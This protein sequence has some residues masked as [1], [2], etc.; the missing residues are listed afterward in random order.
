MKAR[1]PLSA[2]ALA[3][4]A[5]QASATGFNDEA[6]WQAAVGSFQEEQ[7]EGFADLT[8][9]CRL[10][11]VDIYMNRLVTLTHAPTVMSSGTT[12]GS[13]TSGVNVLVN[14]MTPVLPGL[15][16]IRMF[17]TKAG[18]SI[19]GL[20]YWNT[21]GDDSTV[22]RVY[23]VNGVLLETVDTGTNSVVFNGFV[24]SV[25]V[26]WVEIDAGSIGNGYITIDDLQVAFEPVPDGVTLPSPDE[27]LSD[28]ASNFVVP[29]IT[30]CG[31]D[32][33]QVELSAAPG[34]IGAVFALGG[35][36]PTPLGAVG[37]LAS[38]PAALP[39]GL[40][41]TNATGKASIVLDLAQLA[42]SL[43]PSAPVPETWT[44]QVVW[45]KSQ[46][47][48]ERVVAGHHFAVEFH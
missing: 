34:A 43:P 44:L 37:P 14:Q 46:G 6:A 30:S 15:G 7:F 35:P 4:S 11:A 24:S 38:N 13:S 23:D 25:T 12:G 40:I 42:A 2:L 45:V 26:G 16:P 17:S 22:L 36:L 1:Y 19:K 33:C 47:A 31:P 21:G 8:P 20:G 18:H 48:S 32:S 41:Q 27:Q 28:L 9:V 29:A 10:P 3:L 39:V 5:A